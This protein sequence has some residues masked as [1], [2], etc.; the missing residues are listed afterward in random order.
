MKKALVTGAAGF[1][2][3]HVV[4]ELLAKNVA[5]R[6]VLRP[7]E[8][9]LNIDGLD[10]EIVTG[11]ILDKA[12]IKKSMEGIDHVFH[13]A[14]IYSIWMEDWKPLWEINLQGTQNILWAAL[15]AEVQRVVYTSSI[16]AIGILPGN[17]VA[18][19][20]TPFNQYKSSPYVL[21]KYLSQKI[22]LG[23]AENGLDVVIVNPALPFG[24]GDRGPTPTGQTILSLINNGTIKLDGGFNGVDVR[25]VAKGHVLAAEKGRTG[26]C[27]ILGNQN[28]TLEEFNV[29]V[30]KGYGKK[31][32]KIP[33]KV[34]PKTMER[35]AYMMEWMADNVT[36]KT[37]F[38]TVADAKYISQCLYVDNS[39]AKRELG[40]APRDVAVSIRDAIDWF[41]VNGYIKK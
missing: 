20:S 14:A 5:V 32:R 6:A 40:F 37:P 24:P 3:S 19:E 35:M 31:L 39:K 12:F 22:A 18:N 21:S 23:F 30:E 7:G 1:I 29:L 27:Y 17:G 2:G 34:K 4:H 38:S 25:D 26:E 15:K 8:P 16:T 41:R 36:H 13:L 10:I 11:D 33:I 9:T 28:M